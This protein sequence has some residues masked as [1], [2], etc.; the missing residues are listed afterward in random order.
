MIKPDSRLSIQTISLDCIQ[1][2]EYQN[3]YVEKLLDYIQLLLKY[4]GE[5]AGLLFVTPSNTH[6]GMFAL[7]DGYHKFCGYIMTGRKDALC[8]VIEE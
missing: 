1:V 5:Y 3:R 7:L 2:K 8:V 6:K 4:P